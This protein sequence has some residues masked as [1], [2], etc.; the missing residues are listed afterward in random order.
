[1]QTLEDKH[2][3]DLQEHYES[4][5]K[6]TKEYKDYIKWKEEYKFE[7]VN[8]KKGLGD[9][10]EDITEATGIKKLVK[11]VAGEDCGCNERKE[12][13]NKIFSGQRKPQ[14]LTEVEY[15]RLYD[16]YNNKE[17]TREQRRTQGEFI[18]ATYERVFD[19]YVKSSGCL[20]CLAPK[21]LNKLKP[22]FST[23]EQEKQ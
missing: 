3:L 7:E 14:C 20:N 12:K 4:M 19:V 1:M 9:I 8:Q 21:L 10:V 15:N 17:T 2:Y 6:R 11:F 18:K 5:D 13:L 23:Y 16:I 22:V